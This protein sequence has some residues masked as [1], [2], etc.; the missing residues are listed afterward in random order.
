MAQSQRARMRDGP[1]ADLF[2]STLGDEYERP[3]EPAGAEPG[4][5]VVAK[6]VT[7]ATPD[8]PLPAPPKEVERSVTSREALEAELRSAEAR[9]ERARNTGGD[10]T[11]TLE[12]LESELAAAKRWADR[13]WERALHCLT[14]FEAR[15]GEAERN[16][17]RAE[18]LAE[19]HSARVPPPGQPRANQ[20][21][22][23]AGF[24]E[25]DR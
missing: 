17:A 16:A 23:F 2:R 5:P 4:E 1:L 14:E 11:R 6:P 22:A 19:W 3:V 9:L 18:E 8:Q 12:A 20:P 10:L 13:A 21:A 24:G 7:R 25:P 15:A